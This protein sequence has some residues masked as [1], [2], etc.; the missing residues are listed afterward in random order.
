MK[1]FFFFK[2][3]PIPTGGILARFLLN[4][5]NKLIS[6]LFNVSFK[7]FMADSTVFYA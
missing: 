7:H 2:L 4:N 3:S 6:V 1:H 5:C